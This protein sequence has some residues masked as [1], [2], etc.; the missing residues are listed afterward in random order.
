MPDNTEITVKVTEDILYAAITELYNSGRVE[1]VA[2]DST[3]VFLVKDGATCDECGEHIPDPPE[4]VTGG[5][6]NRH[7]ADSCSLYGATQE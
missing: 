7:H 6:V 4:G 5:L 1:W 2:E 3:R